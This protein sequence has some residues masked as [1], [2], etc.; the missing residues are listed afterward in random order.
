MSPGRSSSRAR[1]ELLV[2]RDDDSF[3]IRQVSSAAGWLGL[4]PQHLP[5]ETW[6][7]AE[8]NSPVDHQQRF[9]LKNTR[10]DR[11]VMLSEP[12]RFL[13]E[14]MD[15]TTSLQDMATAYVLR[16]GAFDFELIPALIGK[17]QRARL[18]TLEPVSALRR[19]L[20]RNRER[21]LVHGVEQALTV[22]ERVNVSSRDVHTFFERLYRW[23]GFLLFT[24]AVLL[25]CLALGVVGV[26]AGVRL[27]GEADA[28]ARGLGANPIA[29]LLSVKLLFLA[30]LV[31]HQ[32]VHGLALIHYGRRV[33]EFGFTFLHGFVP[34]FYV[35]V[36]DIFMASRRARIVTALSGTLVH[37]VLGT[38]W[39]LVAIVSPP[40]FLQAFAATS[41]MIQ[42]QA[43]FVALYPC[44]FIE[45][46]GY[47]IL[48]DLLGLPTLRH[49]AVVYVGSLFRG[50]PMVTWG[51]Q[52]ALWVG[53]VVL[54]TVSLAAFIAFN[55]VLIAHAVA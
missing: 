41:G 7:L 9:I 37:L 10:S 16:Y 32:L 18:L 31:V 51:R 39:F 20:A 12:E 2:R 26:V 11:Y 13:W 47:H 38:L 21:R 4:R 17:L 49:D 54:S 33:R 27:W 45:M 14:R 19:V 48:V 43:F 1:L 6:E 50:A 24:R 15:G 55:V 23:G 22:L 52:A 29:A 35:D 36:T 42:W 25:L 28:V 40:G 30:T 5:A 3:E 8:V 53:Y 46:D 44:C 34:T